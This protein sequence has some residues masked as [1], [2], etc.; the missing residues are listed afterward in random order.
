MQ[1]LIAS[2]M[3]TAMSAEIVTFCEQN[4]ISFEKLRH[5]HLEIRAVHRQNQLEG[6]YTE[7]RH[8]G[9]LLQKRLERMARKKG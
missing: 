2:G 4:G 6:R 8:C 5:C 1:E 7:V 3:P 9:F